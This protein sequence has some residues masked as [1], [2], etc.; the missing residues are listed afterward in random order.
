MEFG[1]FHIYQPKNIS[2]DVNGLIGSRLSLLLK[3]SLNPMELTNYQETFALVAKLDTIQ[4]LLSL[5][6]NLNW[7]LYQ[8]NV[9]NVFLNEDLEEDFYMEIPPS[10]ET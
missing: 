1:K 5:T 2:W 3:S 9:K 6:M 4:V 8:L 7:S 10:F